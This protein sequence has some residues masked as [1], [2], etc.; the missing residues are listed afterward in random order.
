MRGPL[1]NLNRFAT[2]EVDSHTKFHLP[3]IVYRVGDLAEIRRLVQP[4][5]I[6]AV[7]ARIV[8]LKVVKDVGKLHRELQTNAFGNLNIVRPSFQP[9]AAPAAF[10]LAQISETCTFANRAASFEATAAVQLAKVAQ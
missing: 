4:Q 10:R 1:S 2:L 5:I 8:G 9:P 6:C 3:R 7:I